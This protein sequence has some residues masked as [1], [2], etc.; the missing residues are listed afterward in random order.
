MR[1]KILVGVLVATFLIS[2]IGCSSKKQNI[3][4]E[5]TNQQE[6]SS[7]NETEDTKETVVESDEMNQEQTEENS[8]NQAMDRLE[9]YKVFEDNLGITE[10]QRNG[11]I[12]E[13]GTEPYEIAL[14]SCKYFLK[15]NNNTVLNDDA[16]NPF[17]EKYQVDVINIESTYDGHA[18]PADYIT[19]DGNL[20]R[21]TIIFVHGQGGTR[22]SNLNI[23]NHFLELGYNTLSFDLRNSGENKAKLTTF[24][25]LEKYDL[26]DCIDYID[27][28]IDSKHKIVVWGCSYGGSVVSAT[29]GCEDANDKVDAAILDSP[30]ASMKMMLD[31]RMLSYVSEDELDYTYEC[32]DKFMDYMFGFTMSDADGVAAISKTTI[33]TLLITSNADTVVSKDNAQALYDA[34]PNDKKYIKIFDTTAHVDAINSETETYMKLVI[35]FIDGK[36]Y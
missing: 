33:P 21:D 22:R 36:L 16:L 32:C 12:S 19:V 29:L 10:E 26:L 17:R 9:V 7:I 28:R 14:S 4:K 11:F 3:I 31:V 1:K 25:A 30:A 20:D 13:Y 5:E 35:D 23:A 34:I 27:E 6:S 8:T 2:A 24:G 18:I 15:L